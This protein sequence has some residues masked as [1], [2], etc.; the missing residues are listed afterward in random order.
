MSITYQTVP[1]T[2]AVRKLILDGLQA[3]GR[4]STGYA[5][6]HL[7]EAPTSF[8]AWD[9]KERDTKE[10]VGALVIK[11]FWGA[12]HL[13]LLYVK[14]SHRSFG[15][16]STLMEQALSFARMRQGA[17]VFVETLSFQAVEFYTKMGFI[18][19]FVRHGYTQGISFHYLKK[20]L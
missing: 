20:N 4:Q 10:C 13:Q 19:E 12:F 17:F 18:T 5:G 14:E 1:L 8:E 15:I 6:D 7:E 16:A 2:P 3:Y 9:A 11:P